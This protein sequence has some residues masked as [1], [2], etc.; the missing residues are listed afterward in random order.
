VGG[1]E[2]AVRPARSRDLAAVAR[3]YR[4]LDTTHQVLDVTL[5]LRDEAGRKAHIK[6][7]LEANSGRFAV[8][9]A[10]QAVVGFVI[11][12]FARRR[13]DVIILALAVA[14]DFRRRGIGTLLVREI[15]AWAKAQKARFV[16]LEVYE[17][18]PEAVAFYERLGYFT[19]S[20]T[21]REDP[22]FELS[23]SFEGAFKAP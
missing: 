8:A 21:M 6:H 20:R 2:I 1:Q 4:D 13:P 9:C 10:G 7:A 15:E 18:N 17:F 14:S 22:A 12:A 19:T 16:E 5:S 11:G 23:Y 3:L